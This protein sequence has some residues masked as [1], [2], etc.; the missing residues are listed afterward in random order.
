MTNTKINKE[1]LLPLGI[2]ATLILSAATGAVWMSSKL[3]AINY[4]MES[5]TK[6]V[7]NIQKKLDLAEQDHW[8]F[9]EMRLW[10]D[11]LKAKNSSMDIPRISR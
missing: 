4:N 2:V 8:T 3:Q 5:L 7:K 10:V 9:R 1:T 6:E 11:L